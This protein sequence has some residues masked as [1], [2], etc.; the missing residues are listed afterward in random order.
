MK[1]YKYVRLVR[2]AYSEEYIIWDYNTCI[3]HVHLHYAGMLVY[4]SLMLEIDLTESERVMLVEQIDDNIISSYMP[5]F[6]RDNLLV[7]IY[8]VKELDSFTTDENYLG[9]DE[10]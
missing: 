9:E 2:T 5:S 4:M 3:G 8:R 7:T 10:E 6:D 1:E